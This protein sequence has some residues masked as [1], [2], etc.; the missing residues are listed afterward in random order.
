MITPLFAV[1]Y[2]AMLAERV[3]ELVLN[4]RNVAKLQA[5]GARWHGR[6]GFGLILASQ[7]LLFGLIVAEVAF[8]PWAGEHI[9]T[10]PLVALLVG[11]Q[12]LRY[13]AITTLGWRWTIRVVTVPGAPR[14]LG[15]PYRYYPHPNYVA[16][17]AEAILLPL[18]FGAWGTALV[19]VPLQFLALWRRIRLEEGALGQAAARPI[20]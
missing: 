19:V 3:F 6:D 11:A 10:W 20:A 2:L 15:G 14:L 1:V 7:T 12:A 18:A 8:S 4:R 13:W 16:V 9:L 17:M 5:A